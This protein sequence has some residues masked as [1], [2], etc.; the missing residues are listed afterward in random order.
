M[1][2]FKNIDKSIKYLGGGG[3]ISDG[4]FLKYENTE[5]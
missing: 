3:L 5:F 2:S 4:I 1:L